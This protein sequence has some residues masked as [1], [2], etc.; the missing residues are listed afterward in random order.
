[1]DI[2]SNPLSNA[3]LYTFEIQKSETSSI[4]FATLLNFCDKLATFELFESLPAVDAPLRANHHQSR[5]VV[6]TPSGSSLMF[7]V[8]HS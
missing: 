8:N 3:L 2:I 7:L 1:L 6:I 5:K 4:I